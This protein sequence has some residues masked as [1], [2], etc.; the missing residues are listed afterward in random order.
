MNTQKA[1]KWFGIIFVLI[2]VLGFIP[3]ITSD[4]YLLGIF[5]VDTVHN[6]IHLLS[7]I[8]ALFCANNMGAAK[9]YFKIFGVVYAL[10]TIMGFLDGTSILGIFSV[11]GADNILHLLIAAVALYIG[12]SGP[13]T[14]SGAQPM[15]Q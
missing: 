1:A 10:V 4:G 12:F 14:M 7:G 2:G 5:E 8:I 6:V 3:G 15:Q 11:N 13:K 9:G